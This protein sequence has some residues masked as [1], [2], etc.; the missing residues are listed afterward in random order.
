[1]AM[2]VRDVAGVAVPELAITAGHS[3]PTPGSRL[4]RCDASQLIEE[5]EHERQVRRCDHLAFRRRRDR[6]ASA[7]RVQR[8]HPAA[9]H[10]ANPWRRLCLEPRLVDEK[11]IVL[12]TVPGEHEHLRVVDSLRVV[13]CFRRKHDLVTRA[14]P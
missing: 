1:M 8:V 9:E 3:K 4:R 10:L 7:I 11:R 6:D 14:G 12:H 13:G 5:V 2:I